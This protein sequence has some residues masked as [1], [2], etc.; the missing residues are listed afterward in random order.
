MAILKIERT[1]IESLK[2]AMQ[3]TVGNLAD[4]VNNMHQS[5]ESYW[6]IAELYLQ[7]SSLL[8][9]LGDKSS[10]EKSAIIDFERKY[11]NLL[12]H[13][14]FSG[15]ENEELEAD[16]TAALNRFN[17]CERATL[18]IEC[19]LYKK[20]V[21]PHVPI[22]VSEISECFEASD[23]TDEWITADQIETISKIV[24]RT[25]EWFTAAK[26]TVAVHWVY[27]LYDMLSAQQSSDDCLF[28]RDFRKLRNELTIE[29][30]FTSFSPANGMPGHLLAWLSNKRCTELIETITTTPESC[31]GRDKLLIGDYVF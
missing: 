4:S 1:S 28:S 16:E 25:A 14:L 26:D 2:A 15:F 6:A 19:D 9:L 24:Y 3:V 23:I 29:E 11:G 7:V 21:D 13:T 31:D 8:I 27:L 22:C 5:N 18:I 10:L 12:T 20:Y 17:F 30:A